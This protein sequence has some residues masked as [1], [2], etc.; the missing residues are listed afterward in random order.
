MKKQEI[1]DYIFVA[2]GDD[3]IKVSEKTGVPYTTIKSYV[4][5][6][7]RRPRRPFFEKIA[8][9]YNMRIV[10]KGGQVELVPIENSDNKY[11]I[12]DNDN[13]FDYATAKELKLLFDKL[14][15]EGYKLVIRGLAKLSSAE[16]EMVKKLLGRLYE[17]Q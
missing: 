3:Y 10:S 17:D 1:F 7:H 5:A 9:Q 15:E 4:N 8:E 2:Y 14:G 16:L 13:S 6:T 11:F 12:V